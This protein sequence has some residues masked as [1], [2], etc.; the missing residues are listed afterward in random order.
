[1]HRSQL[2]F[3][4]G[5]NRRHAVVAAVA[6]FALF[7]GAAGGAVATHSISGQAVKRQRVIRACQNLQNGLLR[8]P[9]PGGR[10]WAGELQL[11]WN[12]RGRTG[13]QGPVGRRGA[14]GARG[15]VGTP[16]VRGA[17]GPAGARG[18]DGSDGA[19][20]AA[21]GPGADGQAGPRGPHGLQGGPGPQGP[22]GD[23]GP[24]GDT[25]PQGPKGLTGPQG[26]PLP[27]KSAWDYLSR[28]GE[29]TGAAVRASGGSYCTTGEVM[30]NAGSVAKGVPAAGQHLPTTLYDHLYSLIGT[31][32]GGD[33]DVVFDLPDLRPVTP[34]G[35]TYTICDYG[36]W[37]Q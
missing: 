4:M 37:P 20:G 2:F 22:Q 7:A 16:G 3:A 33:G 29:N 10:C 35:M 21:G 11:T 32:Y 18:L 19:S 14:G 6:A 15:G 28:F 17:S 31:T 23:Q 34:N 9:R 36:L 26:V 12:V 13:A 27:D 8:I 24:N 30:L 5:F 1:M 25:G